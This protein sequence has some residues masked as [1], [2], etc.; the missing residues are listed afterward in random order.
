MFRVG[1]TG[2]IGSGKSTVAQRFAQHGVTVID[3]DQIA[4]ALLSASTPLTQHIIQHFG[5]SILHQ[6]GTLD[7]RQ[8][9]QLI[10][11]APQQKAWLENIMHPAITQRMLALSQQ[12]T[13]Y[14]VL[15]IPL[16]VE[17]HAA[18]PFALQRILLVDS[19]VALQVART[20]AR[21]HCS[22]AHVQ[23][24]IAQQ[25]TREQRLALADDVIMNDKDCTYLQ[26]ETDTLHR[27]YLSLSQKTRHSS[28]DLL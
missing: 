18:S 17:T 28:N 24:I 9:R 8:L 19:P 13:S 16:L 12:A 6:D 11:A 2:G 5:S 21:D 1:L 26:Q 23:N 4:N 25:A 22:L 20:V 15:V 27:S 14:C 10:F 3:A 7:R